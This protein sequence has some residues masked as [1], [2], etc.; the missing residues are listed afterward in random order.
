MRAPRLTWLGGLFGLVLA[1]TGGCST[2]HYYDIDVKFDTAAGQFAGTNE[3]STIQ[4]CVMVVSGADSGSITMGLAQN[5]PPMTAAG[6]GTDMGVVEF[7]SFADSGNLTFTFNAYD[8]MTTADSCKTGV[9][10]K[11]IAA[12]SASTV[13]DTITFEKVAAGCV[14]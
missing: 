6:I 4:R 3:I 7:S 14:P 11:T 5:C 12:S 9:G 13:M 8:D 1:A 2:Y 10:T